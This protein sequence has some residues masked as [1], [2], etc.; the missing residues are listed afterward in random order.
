MKS[1]CDTE[2]IPERKIDILTYVA[3]VF[4]TSTDVFIHDGAELW[5][6]LLLEVLLPQQLPAG[7]GHDMML[8]SATGHDLVGRSFDRGSERSSSR[9]GRGPRRGGGPIPATVPRPQAYD[10]HRVG[11]DI[12]QLVA[13][14]SK[15]RRGGGGGL[16]R[17][18]SEG[19]WAGGNRVHVS[20]EVVPVNR[21]HGSGDLV[22]L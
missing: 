1:K 17:G 16:A 9:S 15:G 12:S 6:L 13:G 5:R 2:F 7:R 10:G 8:V 22:H 4:K 3:I 19:Q 21:D 11:R 18:D 20:V 14:V